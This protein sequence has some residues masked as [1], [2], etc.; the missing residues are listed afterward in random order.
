MKRRQFLETSALGCAL[1]I[2]Q[3]ASLFATSP[4]TEHLPPTAKDFELE[5]LTWIVL[6]TS[7]KTV[8]S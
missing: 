3:P 1:A 4:S 8:R 6:T 5:E 2:S 7:T